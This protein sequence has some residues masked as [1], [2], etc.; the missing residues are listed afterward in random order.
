VSLVVKTHLNNT[1]ANMHR[2]LPLNSLVFAW[3]SHPE[4]HK[5]TVPRQAFIVSRRDAIDEERENCSLVIACVGVKCTVCVKH[6]VHCKQRRQK[7]VLCF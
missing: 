4:Q 5:S 1:L 7:C 2:A 6:N 3:C